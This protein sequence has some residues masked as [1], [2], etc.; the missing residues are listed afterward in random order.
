M[1]DGGGA[2]RHDNGSRDLQFAGRKGDTLRMVS[3]VE[4]V[5][6]MANDAT[7]GYRLTRR[8]RNDTFPPLLIAQM[9]HL[10][11]GTTELEAKHRQQIL[12]LEQNPSFQSV[13]H[14]DRM[15]QRG[16]FNDIVN[17]GCQDQPEILE[18]GN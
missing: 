15:G 11:V 16:L 2:R 14:V 13:A 4:S 6:G 3:Y 10:V 8:A 17:P 9:S 18:W 7:P 1:F 12:P 5:Y